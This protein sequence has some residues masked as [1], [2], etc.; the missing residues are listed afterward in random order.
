MPLLQEDHP[1]FGTAGSR[2]EVAVS[3]GLLDSSGGGALSRAALVVSCLRSGGITGGLL[4]TNH[5]GGSV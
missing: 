5:C 2:K 3:V 1:F 4:C